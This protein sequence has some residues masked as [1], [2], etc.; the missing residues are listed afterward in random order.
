MPRISDGYIF[1]EKK[2]G[3]VGNARP[4]ARAETKTLLPYNCQRLAT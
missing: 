1:A 3:P 2:S 4:A